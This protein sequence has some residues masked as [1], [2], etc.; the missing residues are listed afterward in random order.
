MTR[1]IKLSGLYGSAY[2]LLDVKTMKYIFL[3]IVI[4]FLA[5]PAYAENQI[6]SVLVKKS[7]RKMYLMKKGKTVKEYKLALAQTQGVIKKKRGMR[8]LLK[9]ITF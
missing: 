8:E 5:F 4:C 6:D 2:R 1:N 3:T 7:E 9:E